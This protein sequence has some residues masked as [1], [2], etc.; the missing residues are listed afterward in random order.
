M[1]PG[2]MPSMVISPLS[3][4]LMIMSLL[5]QYVMIILQFKGADDDVLPEPVHI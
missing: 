5:K 1:L 4:Y 3:L 2:P